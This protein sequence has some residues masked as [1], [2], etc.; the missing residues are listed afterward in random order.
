MFAVLTID[1]AVNALRRR[2]RRAL[3]FV[4]WLVLA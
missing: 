1:L 4:P 2:L 3:W